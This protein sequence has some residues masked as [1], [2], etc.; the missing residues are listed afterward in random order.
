MMLSM[1]GMR[2]ALGPNGVYPGGITT[3][4][5]YKPAYFEHLMA[6]PESLG[7]QDLYTIA[8][9][10]VD[11]IPQNYYFPRW[12]GQLGD[13]LGANVQR[14]QAGELSPEDVLAQSASDI[15]QPDALICHGDSAMADSPSAPPSC[16]AGE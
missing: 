15:A 13:I 1:D 14:L 4:I 2:A 11:Q 12:F 5:P 16:F 7:G 8:T 6:N 10:L 3:L 9:G